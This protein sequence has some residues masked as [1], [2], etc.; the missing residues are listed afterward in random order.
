M[1][2]VFL[3]LS[4]ML[5]SMILMAI[6]QSIV[7]K[8]EG[9]NFKFHK[10]KIKDIEFYNEKDVKIEYEDADVTVIDDNNLITVSSEDF[11]KISLKLPLNKEYNVQ[12]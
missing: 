3:V 1:K 5:V 9:V 11:S 12:V 4:L 7:V 6:S 2:K 10:I 8:A